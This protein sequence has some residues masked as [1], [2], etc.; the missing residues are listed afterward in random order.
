MK[1]LHLIDSAGLYGAEQVVLALAEAQ[2]AAG[3]EAAIG[4]IGPVG[5]VAKQI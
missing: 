3:C 4:S 2:I 1:V 5:A